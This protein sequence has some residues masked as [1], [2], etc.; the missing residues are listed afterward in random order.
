LCQQGGTGERLLAH[1]ARRHGP[2][3]SFN[4]RA[5]GG[6]MCSNRS[7]AALAQAGDTITE[8]S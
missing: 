4:A 6:I 1:I 7:G 5:W 3:L 8:V 2:V